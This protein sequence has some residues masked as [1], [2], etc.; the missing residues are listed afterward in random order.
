MVLVALKKKRKKCNYP[1]HLLNC[2][3]RI[4]KAFLKGMKTGQEDEC[5]SVMRQWLQSEDTGRT[6]PLQFAYIIPFSYIRLLKGSKDTELVK[7][8]VKFWR[9]RRKQQEQ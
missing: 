6:Q 3:Y 1:L 2:C 9:N 4:S 8:P 7:I 5:V